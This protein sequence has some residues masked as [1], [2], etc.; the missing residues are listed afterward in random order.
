MFNGFGV[1][2]DLK[3]ALT[4]IGF[5]TDDIIKELKEHYNIR[6]TNI[7][8]TLG[9]TTEEAYKALIRI[10]GAQSFANMYWEDYEAASSPLF[11]MKNLAE[12][13][14][15]YTELDIVSIVNIKKTYTRLLLLR[16]CQTV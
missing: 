5:A 3:A 7:S 16:I 10:Y 11:Y 14:Q 8:S 13:L 12:I 6:L 1:E 2:K 9:L 4:E 15:S